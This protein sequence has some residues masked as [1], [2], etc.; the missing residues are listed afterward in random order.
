MGKL[1]LFILLMVRPRPGGSG[2]PCNHHI[3]D[4]SREGIFVEVPHGS[5]SRAWHG[6]LR[7]KGVVRSSVAFEFYARRHPRRSLQAGEYFFDQCHVRAGSFLEAREWRSI[8]TT[9]HRARRGND[10]RYRARPGRRKFHARRRIP[11]SGERSDADSGPRSRGRNSG[12]IS[13]SGNLSSFPSS[14]GRGAHRR[15]G[16]K[17]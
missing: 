5:S 14:D 4:F 2:I 9:F 17:I 10:V 13:V 16:E 1:L 7:T 8:R 12:R 3:R 11:E 15:H 6:S